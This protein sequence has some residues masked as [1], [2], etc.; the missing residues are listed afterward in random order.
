[1]ARRRRH[2]SPPPPPPPVVV[3]CVAVAVAVIRASV[4]SM[5]VAAGRLIRASEVATTA[6]P[7]RQRRVPVA[8]ALVVV[9][10]EF[11]TATIARWPYRR[12]LRRLCRHLLRLRRLRLRRLCRRLRLRRRRFRRPSRLRHRRPRAF[13]G[14]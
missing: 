7:M 1:M 8:M 10:V 3:V 9:A 11:E 12:R 4:V 5:A 13:R 6:A 2:C 14:R